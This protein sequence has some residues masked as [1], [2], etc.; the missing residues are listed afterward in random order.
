MGQTMSL[1]GLIR[2]KWTAQK[3]RNVPCKLT[4]EPEVENRGNPLSSVEIFPEQKPRL[5][6]RGPRAQDPLG[7]E[8]SF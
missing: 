2:R 8:A 3:D 7:I 5:H 6:S 4:N 1:T